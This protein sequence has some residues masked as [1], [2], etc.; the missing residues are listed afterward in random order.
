MDGVQQEHPVLDII[1]LLKF[2]VVVPVAV[3][4]VGWH[5]HLDNGLGHSKNSPLNFVSIR[6]VCC[7]LSVLEA[8]RDEKHFQIQPNRTICAN[9]ANRL[10]SAYIIGLH[11]LHMS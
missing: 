4:G 11:N 5:C 7:C 8:D 3:D 9:K 2:A 10:V 1:V 6:S